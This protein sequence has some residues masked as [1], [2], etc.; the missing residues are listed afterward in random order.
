MTLMTS[1]NDNDGVPMTGN[2][3]LVRDLLR[4]EW[5]YNGFVVSDWAMDL[6][7]IRHMQPGL[8]WRPVWIWI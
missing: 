4:D 2:R 1:F 5:N 7:Q 8:P 6:L 3:F